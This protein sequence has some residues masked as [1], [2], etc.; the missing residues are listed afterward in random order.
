MTAAVDMR[1]VSV[2]LSGHTVL[3]RIHL[4]LEP[5]DFMAVLGPNGAGKST[6]LQTLPG[7]L[8]CS[9]NLIVL[10]ENVTALPKRALGHLRR[11]IGYVPQLYARPISV[12]PLSVREVVELG[13]TGV[14]G[15]GRRLTTEDRNIRDRVMEQTELTAIADRSFGVLS[16]GEQRKVYLARALAQEPD[17][18]LLD[19]PA[20]HLDFR[21]QETI[22]QLLGQVWRANR[23]SV[24][25]VTHDLRHLPEGVSRVALLDRGTV[26]RVGAPA[27]TLGDDVISTLFDFPLRVIES[28]GRY[29]A[30]PEAS[31]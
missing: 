7:L 31:A 12:L 30:L 14:R 20:G 27:D 11:R 9:G 24:I 15:M 5:G 21:W 6:L 18:L 29:L 19:E 4:S 17:L 13:R 1:E 10:G 23:L 28:R 16:G 8:P 22:T 26:R 2:K 25:M 3:D